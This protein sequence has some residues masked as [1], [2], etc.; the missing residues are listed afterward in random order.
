MNH[1]TRF[2]EIIGTKK[3]HT[4]NYHNVHIL[5]ISDFVLDLE[6]PGKKKMSRGK[7]T[8]L[9]ISSLRKIAV[10]C[11]FT[12]LRVKLFSEEYF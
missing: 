7:T 12:A 3:T 5:G 6:Y 1:S 8:F 11:T 2:D 9:T 4:K 10:T